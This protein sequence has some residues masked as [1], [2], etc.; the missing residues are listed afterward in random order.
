MVLRDCRELP[1]WEM[2][3]CLC[4]GC[5]TGLPASRGC[6][7]RHAACLLRHAACG[8]ATKMARFFC[9]FSRS[10]VLPCLLWC[11][12][13]RVNHSRVVLLPKHKPVARVLIARPL[14]EARPRSHVMRP[15]QKIFFRRPGTYARASDRLNFWRLGT[16][17]TYLLLCAFL[18]SNPCVL[19]RLGLLSD[20]AFANF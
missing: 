14:L 16:T 4:S 15:N 5:W 2:Q 3:K 10:R 20:S 17:P 18:T 7:R 9:M 12:F 1:R 11:C 6:A 13:R 19:R 8:P